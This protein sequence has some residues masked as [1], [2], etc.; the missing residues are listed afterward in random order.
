[1]PPGVE[2]FKFA[3]SLAVFQNGEA[4]MMI[5]WPPIGRWAAGYGTNEKALAFVP[6]SKIAGKVGYAL[7]AR[8]T[9]GTGHRSLRSRWLR[10]ARTRKRHICSSSG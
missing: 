10:P 8:R 7:A 5:S 2:T 3:E 1:M 6:K 9:A 4:A